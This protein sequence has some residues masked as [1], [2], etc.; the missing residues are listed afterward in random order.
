VLEEMRGARITAKESVNLNPEP[1]PGLPLDALVEENLDGLREML[2]WPHY[3]GVLSR[4]TTSCFHF[5]LSK[6]VKFSNYPRDLT[7]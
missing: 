7:H 6:T 2:K 4:G 5:R 1:A 3:A